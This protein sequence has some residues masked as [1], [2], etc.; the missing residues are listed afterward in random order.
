[1]CS[2]IK[3]KTVLRIP[4]LKEFKFLKNK[5]KQEKGKIEE[6]KNHVF[7]GKGGEED[8]LLM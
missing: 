3:E 1:M 2:A 7:V 6:Q 4:L 5:K 8:I